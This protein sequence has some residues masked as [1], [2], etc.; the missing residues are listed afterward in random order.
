MQNDVVP[1]EESFLMPMIINVSG[2]ESTEDTEMVQHSGLK[3][4]LSDS[5]DDHDIDEDQE[6][7]QVQQFNS[8]DIF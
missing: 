5:D 8:K 7:N 2:S 1:N 6:T 3:S 4:R